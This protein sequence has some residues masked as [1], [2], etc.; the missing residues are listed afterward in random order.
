MISFPLTTLNM[1]KTINPD[2]QPIK[3]SVGELPY[4]DVWVEGS[5]NVR[6]LFELLDK[7]SQIPGVLVMEQEKLI[8]MIPRERVYEKLGRP[9][10]VELFLKISSRH[11]LEMLG[12]STLILSSETH[13]DKAVKI[14]LERDENSLYEPIVVEHPNSYRVVS[15]Y[16]LLM[17]QQGTLHDL[18]SE[19]QYLS[20]KDPLTLVNNR[21]GFFDAVNQQLATVRR[22]N[23]ECAVLMIDID[24][25]KSVNDRYG[26]LIGDE[27]IKSVAQNIYN[28]IQEKDVLG[29]FG[30][31]EFVVFLMDVSKESALQQAEELRQ[32]IASKFNVINGL[33][34]RVTVSI[35]LSHS[36]G[37]NTLLDNAL[38]EA[39][40]A[41]YV[42]KNMGRNK[43]MAWEENL[44]QTKNRPV[45]FRATRRGADNLSEEILNQTLHGLLRMLYL[46]DLETETHTLRVSEMALVLAEK[47]GVPEE[48]YDGIRI[49]S[50]LHDIGKIAIPDEILFKR[51]KLAEAEKAV[52]QKHPQ[53][54]RDLI[55]PLLYFEHAL[56]IPYCHH[57]HWDGTGYPR[58]LREEEIPLAAR[59]FSIVDV[60]DALSSDRPYRAAWKENKVREFLIKQTGILFDPSLVP[61]FLESLDSFPT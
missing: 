46:R 25:F 9:F 3:G 7:N 52:M 16:S 14:A 48:K 36:K 50:L 24:N 29:R 11:F 2:E 42:A 47:V 19:V 60:W 27:V 6:R 18:Y 10:G 1:P 5:Q 40:Q 41:A 55:S 57:E 15:M 35:G 30:G 59:I 33:Q 53:Y 37:A 54:A 45:L 51:G 17:A 8:G 23:L 61:L 31:E 56:D 49:G 28:Q 32:S 34:I 20:T 21:R 44:S 4:W 58:G 13:I 12:I 22:F 26:H 39:D 43:V 38:K